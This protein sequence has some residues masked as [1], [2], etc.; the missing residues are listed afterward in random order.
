M[1]SCASSWVCVGT[2]LRSFLH[3]SKGMRRRKLPAARFEP[4][5]PRARWGLRRDR[6]IS[7]LHLSSFPHTV[8]RCYSQL[9]SVELLPPSSP[10]AERPP[11]PSPAP[12]SSATRPTS[13]SPDLRP[14]PA[15]SKRTLRSSFAA[16]MLPPA[17]PPKASLA[18]RRSCSLCIPI[19][20]R[21]PSRSLR[22]R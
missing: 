2:P 1:A 17:S 11:P 20:G 22:G 7:E 8:L 18:S 4:N 13:A 14:F 19:S 21:S 6:S 9:S 12:P 16:S 10:S 15:P 5:K 3:T